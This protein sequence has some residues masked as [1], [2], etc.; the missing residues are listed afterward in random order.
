MAELPP[1]ATAM[2]PTFETS[3]QQ[4][5][6]PRPLGSNSFTGTVNNVSMIL[7]NLHF[8]ENN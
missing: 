8:N 2:N 5:Y 4:A 7:E 6:T 1:A 3:G